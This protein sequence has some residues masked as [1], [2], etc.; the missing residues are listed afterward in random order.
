MVV[1]NA[2]PARVSRSRVEIS[3]LGALDS[4]PM[5]L[6]AVRSLPWLIGE[7]FALRKRRA[8]AI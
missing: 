2:V 7:P 8:Y 4:S 3:Q 6:F 1:C 5:C